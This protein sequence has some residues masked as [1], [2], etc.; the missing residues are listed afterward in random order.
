M[1]AAGDDRWYPNFA[2]RCIAALDADLSLVL[3]TSRI[4]FEQGG[5]LVGLSDA[6]FPLRGTVDVNIRR[7][8]HAPGDNSRMY[9]VF[10]TVA[11]QRSFPAVSFH[12]YDWAFCVATLRFGGHAE[13]PEVLMARDL[14]PTSNYQALARADGSTPLT[15][16]LPLFEMSWWLI[17]KAKIPRNDGILGALMALN[18]NK[19]IEYID[20]FYPRYS[21]LVRPLKVLW[22]RHF[23]WR[24]L[25]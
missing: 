13:I 23:E 3:A 20:H 7:Y 18:I 2:E 25:K 14:T 22:W 15:R 17:F 10:R 19:H 8:L 6:T 21:K 9:G 12:A 5:K 24:F 16:L 11:G 4:A 1:W